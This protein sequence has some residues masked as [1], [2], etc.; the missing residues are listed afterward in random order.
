MIR[1]MPLAT[2][3]CPTVDVATVTG[4]GVARSHRRP[5]SGGEL[6]ELPEQL[7]DEAAGL[8]VVNGRSPR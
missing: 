6:L 1:V 8:G 2:G 5:R 3:R 7:G 4:H